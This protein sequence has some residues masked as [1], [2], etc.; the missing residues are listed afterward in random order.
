MVDKPINNDEDIVEVVAVEDDDLVEV[1]AIDDDVVIEGVLVD[2]TQDNAQKFSARLKSSTGI[3]WEYKTPQTSGLGIEHFRINI[4]NVPPAQ[5][6]RIQA[7]LQRSGINCAQVV[8][9]NRGRF[10]MI[11]MADVTLDSVCGACKEHKIK[12]GTIPAYIYERPGM[13]KAHA[14]SVAQRIMGAGYHYADV[15]SKTGGGGAADYIVIA[16]KK[17]DAPKLDA[18]WDGEKLLT[19][20]DSRGTVRYVN[21]LL[22]EPLGYINKTP[23]FI[24]SAQDFGTTSSRAVVVVNVGGKKLPFYMSSGAAGKT[25]VPTGKWEF[26]C[27]RDGNGWFRKGTLNDVL[28]HYNSPELKYIAD[29]LDGKIGDVRDTTDVL[30]SAGREYLG[31]QGN[32]SYVTQLPRISDTII[33]QD[34]FVP[35]NEG[36]LWLDIRTVKDYLSGL[37]RQQDVAKKMQESQKSLKDKM[38]TFLPSFFGLSKNKENE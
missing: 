3:D 11:E 9:T 4:T 20:L 12:R 18:R 30:L 7:D 26:F 8:N 33:N 19:H 36:N 21:A 38:K 29:A 22:G 14:K 10:L 35:E 16:I 5:I 17:T 24:E 34:V 2:Q 15:L 32:V 28:T 13:G 27:G 1:I 23:F 37:Q 31:G 25:D 6:Q